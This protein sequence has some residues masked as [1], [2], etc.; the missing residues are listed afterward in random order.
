MWKTK[1]IIGGLCVTLGVSF[2]AWRGRTATLGGG[3]NKGQVMSDVGGS[4]I[5]RVHANMLRHV[6]V[7]YRFKVEGPKLSVIMLPEASV[8]VGRTALIFFSAQRPEAPH[9]REDLYMMQAQM[10]ANAQ[11]ISF[12]SPRN[13]TENPKSYDRLFD[14]SSGGARI[15]YGQLTNEGS[16]RAVT[17]LSWDP[18]DLSKE[19]DPH[20]ITKLKQAAHYDLWQAPKWLT[21]RFKEPLAK[22]G[23]RFSADQNSV[24]ILSNEAPAYTLD[25]STSQ[26]SPSGQGIELVRFSEPRPQLLEGTQ[27]LLSSYGLINQEERL[28]P[29]ERLSELISLRA[30]RP[31]PLTKRAHLTLER[32]E[33]LLCPQLRGLSVSALK[34]GERGERGDDERRDRHKAPPCQ[35]T[36]APP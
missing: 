15:L 21:L 11:P 1:L 18:R 28:A 14:T 4:F 8:E 29:L 13:L 5:A 34:R 20:L 31:P 2:G 16:C 10:G 6:Q 12:S 27:E 33:L 19:R 9:E 23:A 3:P 36:R 25:L 7:R 17:Q 32:L 35:A 26:V 22:C 24:V 30:E